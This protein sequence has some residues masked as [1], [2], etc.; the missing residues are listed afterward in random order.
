MASI[1]NLVNSLLLSLEQTELGRLKQISR[2]AL[3]DFLAR[4]ENNGRALAKYAGELIQKE[5]TVLTHSYSSSVAASLELAHDEGK[6]FQVIVTES[7]PVL[8]GRELAARLASKGLS[9][10]LMVD[11]AAFRYLPRAQ[12]VFVGADSLAVQGMINKA[13][14]WGL[15]LAAKEMAVPFYVLASSEKVLPAQ[16]PFA[17]RE[18]SRDPMEVWDNALAGLEVINVYYDLTPLELV[19]AV[20]GEEGRKRP[21]QIIE[22]AQGQAVSPDLL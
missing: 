17:L 18:E 21:A 16:F 5:Y 12:M 7:R 6:R 4:L 11:S 14:T 13:G 19:T 10:K 20:V 2:D 15:A 3:A 22:W 9:V 8:E 1:F